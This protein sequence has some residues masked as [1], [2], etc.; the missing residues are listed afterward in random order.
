M[1]A[2]STHLM[3]LTRPVLV[4][5]LGFQR[6]CIYS[7]WFD[8]CSLVLYFYNFPNSTGTLPW[9]SATATESEN[10]GTGNIRWGRG[11][12]IK[13]YLKKEPAGTM[14]D[15]RI[16]LSWSNSMFGASD[17]VQPKSL[18]CLCLIRFQ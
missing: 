5:G 10:L 4:S 14:Y 15:P 7:L 11:D 6:L 8:D 18:R 13:G 9:L 2:T 3:K 17:T 16:D 12:S 1:C